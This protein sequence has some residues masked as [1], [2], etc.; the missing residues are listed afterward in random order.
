MIDNQ[1]KHIT[2]ATIYNKTALKKIKKDELI[3]LFL[4]QQAKLNDMEFTN[5]KLKEENKKL[6]DN[7]AYQKNQKRLLKEVR[8]ARDKALHQNKQLKEEQNT[9]YRMEIDKLKDDL[10]LTKASHKRLTDELHRQT[11]KWENAPDC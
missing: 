10:N 6:K 7:L 3:K 1:Y 8:S 5:E 4:D 11:K 2:M 9:Q